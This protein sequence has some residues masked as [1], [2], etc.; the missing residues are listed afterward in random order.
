METGAR[1][2]RGVGGRTRSTGETG[3][4]NSR[5]RRGAAKAQCPVMRGEKGRVK[6]SEW[7]IIISLN[8]TAT[9][10]CAHAA[11][12]TVRHTPTA[13][14]S[15][16]TLAVGAVV[17]CSTGHSVLPATTTALVTSVATLVAASIAAALTLVLVLV[18]VVTPAILLLLAAAVAALLSLLSLALALVLV[19]YA[20]IS[21]SLS[22]ALKASKR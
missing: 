12:L 10:A 11:Q 18:V 15:R 6:W 22:S 3:S 7:S 16:P 21:M 4:A 14:E 8:A 20:C 13:L 9:R 19:H 2:E 17:L 5:R 1:S